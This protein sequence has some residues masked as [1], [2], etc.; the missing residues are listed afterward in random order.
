MT[1]YFYLPKKCINEATIYYVNVIKKSLELLDKK[2][3]MKDNLDFTLSNNDYVLTIRLRDFLTAYIKHKPKNTIYWFQGI[4]PEE[5]CLLNN[6]SAKSKIIKLGLDCLEKWVLKKAT[7]I[8][9]VSEEMKNHYKRKYNFIPKNYILMPCFNKQLD[10]KLFYKAKKENSFVYAGSLFT[11]QCFEKTIQLF[12][13]IQDKLPEASLTILTNEID[14]ATEQ[15][16]ESNIKNYSV[17]FI[18]LEQL[19]QELSKYKYGFIIREDILINNVSTPTKMNS[20]LSV[21]LIPIYTDV[22]NDYNINFSKFNYQIRLKNNRGLI[23]WVKE[24]TDFNKNIIDTKKQFIE[25]KGLFDMYYN[26]NNYH[27][28]INNLFINN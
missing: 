12:K 16:K 19:D 10:E 15:L 11:W 21:G 8:F 7:Y 27:K 13:K 18:P 28:K 17:K 25:V 9:F 4:Q 2:V 14:K 6:Y 22:I 5:Y 3:I 24:I 23:N 26:E 20:Y 1:Y